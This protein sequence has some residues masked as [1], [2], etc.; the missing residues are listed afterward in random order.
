[1]VTITETDRV[2]YQPPETLRGEENSFL[3]FI[4]EN[5]DLF[6]R[7][8]SLTY[9]LRDEEEGW[10]DPSKVDQIVNNCIDL[11]RP[12]LPN[13]AN[14]KQLRRAS[15]EIRKNTLKILFRSPDEKENFIEKL[16][17]NSL[18]L[19]RK[20]N[21]QQGSAI[22][23]LYER[24]DEFNRDFHEAK[25]PIVA[26]LQG[27]KTE[28]SSKFKDYLLTDSNSIF[29]FR[30]FLLDKNYASNRE[31]IRPFLTSFVQSEDRLVKDGKVGILGEGVRKWAGEIS[32]KATPDLLGE[33]VASIKS[34]IREW[35]E[36]AAQ[37]EDI[38][39]YLEA[40]SDVSAW[41][42]ELRKAFESSVASKY[43]STLGDIRKELDQFRKPLTVKGPTLQYDFLEEETE[44]AAPAAIENIPD[45]QEGTLEETEKKKYTFGILSQ[46]IGM[47][48]N[49]RH[50]REGELETIL[51]KEAAHLDS[52]DPRMVGDLKRIIMDLR[53]SPYGLGTKK[54]KERS[55]IVG[56]QRLP[57]RSL[58][59][60]TRRGIGLSLDHPESPAIR[61]VYVIYK[62]KAE[63]AIGLEGVWRHE[64]YVKKFGS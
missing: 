38:A 26:E 32:E 60:R 56:N 44:T 64:D 61:I 37:G 58:N 52:S 16:S 53:E 62:N 9:E 63:S 55:V 2:S 4:D 40:R 10:R 42:P 14:N 34:P 47:P 6:E 57:L 33:F 25:A 27:S 36:F 12:I 15:R 46:E 29:A 22:N 18:F 30:D 48:H 19:T 24:M 50:I 8:S 7:H 21:D 45:N 23:A 39:N 1:M 11:V 5:K 54:L 49:I 35:L 31:V 20:V 51:E 13:A 59:P 3:Q 17:R 41:P 43:H 28:L